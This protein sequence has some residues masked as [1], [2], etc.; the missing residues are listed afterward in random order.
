[1]KEQRMKRQLLKQTFVLTVFLLATAGAIRAQEAEPGEPAA[2]RK[3]APV[4]TKAEMPPS[5]TADVN[6]GRGR[7][8]VKETSW[9]FGHVAQDAQ[10]SHRFTLENV[11][12]DTLFIERIKPT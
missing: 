5:G 6:K 3:P 9:D 2:K 12:D 8:F 1:M 10:V 7:L 11:G 4:N